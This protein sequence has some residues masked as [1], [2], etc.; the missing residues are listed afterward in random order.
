[1]EFDVF[2]K[3]EKI[4]KN[5]KI[6]NQKSKTKIKPKLENKK[7]NLKTSLLKFRINYF[8]LVYSSGS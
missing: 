6:E 7:Q 4:E 8:Y 5:Q 3:I 1:M 2:H